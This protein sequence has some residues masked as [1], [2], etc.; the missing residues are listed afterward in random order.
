MNKKKNGNK[1]KNTMY[2]CSSACSEMTSFLL[3]NIYIM[4]VHLF[5]VGINFC[6]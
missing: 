6:G 1:M 2:N 5:S 3:E 4:Q